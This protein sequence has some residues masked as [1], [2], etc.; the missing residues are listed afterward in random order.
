M[1]ATLFSFLFTASS[2][3]VAHPGIAIV[4]DSKG[5]VYYTDLTQ[6]LKI[7]QRGTKSVVVKNV[8]THELYIDKNDNVFGEH[9][10]F[11][12]GKTDNWWHYVWRLTPD[13]SLEKV[14]PPT[15]GF[16]SQH[17]FVKDSQ[18]NGYW[19]DV[20]EHGCLRLCKNSH[21]QS[22]VNLVDSCFN[23]I[24]WLHVS[25]AGNLYFTN[26]HHLVRV[27]QTGRVKPLAK[28]GNRHGTAQ[29]NN[30]HYISGLS[31]D[32]REN[33]YVADYTAR[34]VK[35]VD[36]YGKVS[37]FQTTQT[38]WSPTGTLLGPTGDFWILECS[39]TNEVRVE[40][41]AKDGTRTIY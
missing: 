33:V 19:V 7:D 39:S 14:V 17:S 6:V 20:K 34:A 30:D 12:G 10:W 1:K 40:K 31:T 41:I 9:L 2:W 38:P 28:V 23:K 15:K 27:D 21:N 26:G 13:G 36:R 8:H 11:G 25:R 22:A 4:M 37:V 5:N 24:H 32:A 16:R 18:G 3:A 35:K 29:K